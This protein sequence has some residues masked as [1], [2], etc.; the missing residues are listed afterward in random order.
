MKFFAP[1]SVLLCL[2]AHSALQSEENECHTVL[3]LV[4]LYRTSCCLINTFQLKKLNCFHFSTSLYVFWCCSAS[5]CLSSGIFEC[6]QSILNIS[7]FLPVCNLSAV[8]RAGGLVYPLWAIVQK[9]KKINKKTALQWAGESAVRAC[10]GEVSASYKK[11]RRVV[12]PLR[13]SPQARQ[14]QKLSTVS[15]LQ[16]GPRTGD[17]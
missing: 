4:G 3:L 10:N 5:W 15:N 1:W 13:L 9:T 8:Y 14:L 17:V 16:N 6:Q 7:F 11:C 12:I 2:E